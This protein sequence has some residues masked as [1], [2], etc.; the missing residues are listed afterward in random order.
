MWSYDPNTREYESVKAPVVHVDGPLPDYFTFS[1]G[2]T[3]DN[4]KTRIETIY[5]TEMQELS[6]DSFSGR[7]VD[8]TAE[9]VYDSLK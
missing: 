8:L 3:I 1:D 5:N 7:L 4:T 6:M 9:S 2:A